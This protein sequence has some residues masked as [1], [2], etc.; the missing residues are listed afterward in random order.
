MES[1]Q[2]TTIKSRTTIRLLIFHIV[3]TMV[4]IAI[5][6]LSYSVYYGAYSNSKTVINGKE[7]YLLTILYW[8]VIVA[9][10]YCIP[11]ATRINVAFV[12]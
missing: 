5:L 8:N 2:S 11:M 6:R 1:L 9:Y 12:N 4:L 10:F 7:V 3:F